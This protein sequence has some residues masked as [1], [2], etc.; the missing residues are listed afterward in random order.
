MSKILVVDDSELQ[1]T[2]M[3]EWLKEAGFEVVE[4]ADGRAGLYK[5]IETKPQ[6]IV[7]DVL[8][9]NI[10]GY[11]FVKKIRQAGGEFSE[12][13]I[14]VITARQQME[15]FFDSWQ[16]T[17]FL[18]KGLSKE[19]FLESIRSALHKY[20]KR[21]KGESLVPPVPR[22]KQGQ[23]FII[24]GIQEYVVFEVR[25]YLK[26]IGMVCEVVFNEDMAVQKAAHLRPDYFLCQYWED[27]EVFN[28]QKI[29]YKLRGEDGLEKMREIYFC[30]ERIG[31]EA[32]KD[33]PEADIVVYSSLNQ[34]AEKLRGIILGA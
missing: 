23:K 32:Q 31:I 4:A 10:T 24:T 20:D 1:R 30:S 27:P 16:I 13:P 18:V 11:E 6:L 28:A 7:L 26:K 22:E 9:P 14:V 29:F 25:D 21:G 8:M 19:E 2:L 5:T 34:F 17:D 15:D 3:A 33:L 12:I